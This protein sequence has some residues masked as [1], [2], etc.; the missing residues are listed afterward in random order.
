EKYPGFPYTPH[1]TF[2]S[3]QSLYLAGSS[4]PL[5]TGFLGTHY[6]LFNLT[7]HDFSPVTFS[8]FLFLEDWQP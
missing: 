7:F 2:F 6:K 4:S 3:A 8:C 1:P 5:S